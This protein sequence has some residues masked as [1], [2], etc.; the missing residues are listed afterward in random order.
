MDATT[1]IEGRVEI[2]DGCTVI[3]SA[4]RG[5][6]RIGKNVTIAHSFI[7]PFTSISDNCVLKNVHIENSLVMQ[8]SV[9]SN[10]SKAIDTSLIGP[11]CTVTGDGRGGQTTSLFIGELS[12]VQL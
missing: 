8:G 7:G 1:K 12:K 6:V 4:I 5:P 10:I 3:N 2:E 9:L 11:G